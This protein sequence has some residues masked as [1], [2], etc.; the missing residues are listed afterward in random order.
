MDGRLF[1]TSVEAYRTSLYRV[2]HIAAFYSSLL[3]LGYAP[4][5]AI[6][7]FYYTLDLPPGVVPLFALSYPGSSCFRT[8]AQHGRHTIRYFYKGLS[9]ITLPSPPDR[10]FIPVPAILGLRPE[11]SNWT[12]SIT[13]QLSQTASRTTPTHF[14]RR[15][16][17][18]HPLLAG[19]RR[20]SGTFGGIWESAED[21][22]EEGVA[23]LPRMPFD[24]IEDEPVA[25]PLSFAFPFLFPFDPHSF[26]SGSRPSFS[27]FATYSRGGI[28]TPH[29]PGDH[30]YIAHTSSPPR[31]YRCDHSEGI[32]HTSQASSIR[33]ATGKHA[34]SGRSTSTKAH[35]AYP[36]INQ[37]PKQICVLGVAMFNPFLHLFAQVPP[38]VRANL[39]LYPRSLDKHGE[40]RRFVISHD[41]S[42]GR[43]DPSPHIP[44]PFKAQG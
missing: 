42:S 28:R 32:A 15:G 30:E 12:N 25:N 37:P 21:I 3:S 35:A 1:A 6:R 43:M 8:D 23:G 38:K 10:R 24:E 29:D 44:T 19:Q 5:T 9:S 36:L 31:H 11:H 26:T 2:L 20:R 33:R 7:Q 27:S 40:R 17:I 34:V 13:P 41:G 16:D 22:R 14:T 4:N 39:Q 18:L